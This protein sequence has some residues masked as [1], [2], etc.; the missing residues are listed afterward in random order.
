LTHLDE[1][2]QGTILVVEDSRTQA[3]YLSH[4]LKKEGKK[5]AIAE[6]GRIALAM[7]AAGR[8][9]IIL[10]DILMPEMDGFE[11]CRR[12]KLDPLLSG[13]PVIMV[14]QLFDP[15][16]VLRGLEAG[17]DNFI[18]KPFEPEAVFTRISEALREPRTDIPVLDVT[19]LDVEF[20]GKHYSIRAGKLQILHILLSTY[21]LAIRKNLELHEAQER[22]QALN[23]QLQQIV[24]ELQV[25]NEDLQMEN[26][27]RE[28]VER[29]LAQANKKLQLM[30]SI[31]RH[32][33]VNQL[34]VLQGYLELAGIICRTDTEKTAGHIKKGLAVI[35][36][37]INTIEFTGDYQKIGVTS[38]AWHSITG[39]IDNSQKYTSMG[40]IRLENRI[41]FGAEVFADPLIEKVIFNLIDNALRYGST[42]T[43]IGFGISTDGDRTIIY[44][45]DDGVGIPLDEKERIFS[46]AYGSNTGMGLFLVREILA[47]TD[48]TI[49]ETG[50]PG[51]GARFELVLPPERFRMHG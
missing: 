3:E 22:L 30:A 27:S 11:L 48:I 1:E 34:T 7:I 42:L 12:V 45:E 2:Q 43:R 50:I 40:N 4:I 36:K 9:A 41:P 28:R 29:D 21:D 17:A 15:A 38:P 44:C 24:E 16:D 25:A 49:R 19:P 10:T 35:G 18:I 8:P 39:L 6:N 46:Y 26:N 13:I 20:F 5:T 23:E 47:I 51:K 37:T 33:L 14:T 31:T 32:D